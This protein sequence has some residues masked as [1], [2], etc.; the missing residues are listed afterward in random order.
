MSAQLY[1]L[2]VSAQASRP[3]PIAEEPA[4]PAEL[5]RLLGASFPPCR[6]NNEDVLV[7]ERLDDRQR[8]ARLFHRFGLQLPRRPDAEAYRIWCELAYVYGPGVR[9]AAWRAGGGAA[10]AP[11]VV[12]ARSDAEQ[13][14]YVQAVVRGSPVEVRQRAR[15]LFSGPGHQPYLPPAAPLKLVVAGCA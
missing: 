15:R 9:H 13:A 14:A 2:R 8:L 6:L 1:L 11:P 10:G 3:L 12:T 5:Q 4:W 7:F